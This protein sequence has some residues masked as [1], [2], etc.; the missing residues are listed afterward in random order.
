MTDVLIAFLT[1]PRGDCRLLF[2]DI[3]F[4]SS[5]ET[6][7]LN[8]LHK[9]KPSFVLLKIQTKAFTGHRGPRGQEVEFQYV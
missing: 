1:A 3:N 2:L 7:T 9:G 5:L 8:H 4:C 6:G